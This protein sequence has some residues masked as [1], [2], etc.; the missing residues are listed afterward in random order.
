[1]ASGWKWNGSSRT[2]ASSADGSSR[3]IQWNAPSGSRSRSGRNSC[4]SMRPPMHRKYVSIGELVAD[5]LLEL[6]LGRG[7]PGD[8]HRVG[9]AGDVVEPHPVE[10]V[11]RRGIAPVLAADADLEV[12]LHLPALL[13]PDLH[14]LAH[15]TR[16][17]GDERVLLQDAVLLVVEKELRGVVARQAEAHLGEV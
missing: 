5:G 4:C 6:G 15:P 10:E 8:R 16:V 13:H 3:S 9:R 11:D 1:M 2:F 14:E 17:D 7:Q 12:G